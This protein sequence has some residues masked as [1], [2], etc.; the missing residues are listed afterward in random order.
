MEQKPITTCD[1]P[2]AITLSSPDKVSQWLKNTRNWTKQHE[3]KNSMVD[4]FSVTQLTVQK[5]G[6]LCG[7]YA[8]LPA[9]ENVM[10]MFRLSSTS[11]SF[12]YS[13][14]KISFAST[15]DVEN[16]SSS[17]YSAKRGN[18]ALPGIFQTWL[19]DFSSQKKYAYVYNNWFQFKLRLYQ[20]V[21]TKLLKVRNVFE[22]ENNMWSWPFIWA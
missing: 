14:S 7:N 19:G 9:N 8:A 16:A 17:W 11:C 12:K 20:F 18:C 22:C 2:V 6:N 5:R 13:R 4:N 21:Y 15:F 1:V 10:L 3:G